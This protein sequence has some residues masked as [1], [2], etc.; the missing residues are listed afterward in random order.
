MILESLTLK[1]IRSYKEELIWFE[2]GVSLFE[3]HAGC[4]KSTILMALEFALFGLG[5]QRGESLL[6]KGKAKGSV[7]LILEVNGEQLIITRTLTRQSKK[8]TVS[9]GKGTLT[10]KNETVELSPAD[11]KEQ[12]LE[13]I[14][15]KE[16]INPR[17]NSVIYRFA[18]YTPQEEMKEIIKQKPDLRLQTLR[19][20]FGIE[21]YKNA[22][23]NASLIIKE[24]KGKMEFG[25]GKL[26]R[27][28]GIKEELNE[29]NSIKKEEEKYLE[30][31]LEVEMD[32][33]EKEES[34][35]EKAESEE[36]ISKEI[37]LAT[38]RAETYKKE[39][40][41]CEEKEQFWEEQIEE[42]K[43]RAV[44][45]K[46]VIKEKGGEQQIKKGM[47]KNTLE[48]ELSKIDGILENK[49][50]ITTHKVILGK[51]LD[52]IESKLGKDKEMG[53]NH[54]KTQLNKKE[55]EKEEE[56]SNIERL[57]EQK[58]TMKEDLNFKKQDKIRIEEEIKE[59]ESSK[60]ECPVC[61]KELEEKEKNKIIKA[62]RTLSKALG[63]E[64]EIIEQKYAKIDIETKKAKDKIK[65]LTTL[66]TTLN[67]KL[68]DAK[69]LFEINKDIGIVKKKLEDL[70]LPSI[71]LLPA[72]GKFKKIEDY[73]ESVKTNFR[74]ALEYE[75]NKERVKD[76]KRQLKEEQGKIEN[77]KF[78]LEKETK[79]K[80]VKRELE[81]KELAKIE[82]LLTEN[83][84]TGETQTKLRDIKDN[85]KE[86]G[87]K[88]V[89]SET[90]TIDA[91]EKEK[92]LNKEKEGLELVKAELKEFE[93]YKLWL[94]DC[95]IEGVQLIE[96]MILSE[97]LTEFNN[98]FR[99]WFN[100]LTNDETKT[101]HLDNEFTPVV[102]QDGK[103][104]EIDYLSGGEKTSVAL[105]YRLALNLIVKKVSKGMDTNLL[106]LDEPTDG[107]SKEQL[108]RFRDI[109]DELDYN[110]VVIVSHERE[111]EEFADNIIKVEKINGVSSIIEE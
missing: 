77:L 40:K 33:M 42:T 62:K 34:L 98:N 20:A 35:E 86:I 100:V 37:E 59:L 39:I 43:E 31:Y 1:N 87:N 8:G 22:S 103:K 26:E 94:E 18:V 15:F 28:K 78:S 75:A 55:E 2:E 44:D 58:T 90:R 73:Q 99:E 61:M 6:R 63:T 110:Q 84:I 19:K 16:E 74:I 67:E 54:W 80:E 64:I 46:R 105:A 25:K 51:E 97:L 66:I 57:L 89:R 27:Y 32:L 101:A 41:D 92:A 17:A 11:L 95:F 3:G 91:E 96:K 70:E 45:L 53:I 36:K 81:K 82:T 9:Q 10:Y 24:L 21:D 107:L 71:E 52:K 76:A 4:G 12:V 102:E 47:D 79:D 104:Q 14:N 60:G 83:D 29:V 7:E 106:I 108:F 38:Q 23:E 5:N 30:E 48:E 69:R 109:L 111:L 68:D 13:I 93:D 88:I 50:K 65:Q 85:L 49:N 72:S 56:E